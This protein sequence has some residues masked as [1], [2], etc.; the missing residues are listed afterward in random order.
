MISAWY[1]WVQS[2]PMLKTLS[3]QKPK[4]TFV[5]DEGFRVDLDHRHSLGTQGTEE[6]KLSIDELSLSI[7][8]SDSDFAGREL[9]FCSRCFARGEKPDVGVCAVA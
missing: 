7:V 2:K 4:M 9:L 1:S 8:D 5:V 6:G 3:I